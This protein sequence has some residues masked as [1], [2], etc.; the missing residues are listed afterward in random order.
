[1]YN[2]QIQEL[3][4][5]GALRGLSVNELTQIVNEICKS[6]FQFSERDIRKYLHFFWNVLPADGWDQFKQNKLIEYLSEDQVLNQIYANYI[7]VAR[8]NLS[9]FEQIVRYGSVNEVSD[10][11]RD[12][13]YRGFAMN[14]IRRNTATLNNLIEEADTYSKIMV[15][16]SQVL[17]NLG[18][19]PRKEAL[20]E[21]VKVVYDDTE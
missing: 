8:G 9:V 3:I 2:P 12:E 13:I 5:I 11:I 17:R 7:D 15:R 10:Q 4:E 18:F 1:M 20:R 6:Q 14:V 16:D 21:V 19:K